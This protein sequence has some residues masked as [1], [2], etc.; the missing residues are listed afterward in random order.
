MNDRERAEIYLSL[1]RQQ[2]RGSHMGEKEE[3]KISTKE[4]PW[5]RKRR[6]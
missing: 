6:D 1:Y 5:P 3:P 2:P 4:K